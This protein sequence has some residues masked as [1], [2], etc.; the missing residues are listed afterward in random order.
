MALSHLAKIAR[1][2]G[3]YKEPVSTSAT[4][5]VGAGASGTATVSVPAGQRYFV[6][7]VNITA[8]TNTTVTAVTFDANDTG[9]A[10]SFDCEAVFGAALAADNAISVS[11]S[12]AGTAAED[13]TIEV[14]GYSVEA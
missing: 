7:Q 14:V 10:A 12:N 1:S 8:G 2:L 5:S 9:Q 4:A 6:K 13:L 3:G 11:G